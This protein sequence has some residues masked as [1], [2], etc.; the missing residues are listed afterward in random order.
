MILLLRQSDILCSENGLSVITIPQSKG[1]SHYEHL[2]DKKGQ[3]WKSKLRKTIDYCILKARNWDEFL[4][5][6]DKEKYEIKCGKYISFRAEGQER[7]TRS[8]TPE[9]RYFPAF[10]RLKC[11]CGGWI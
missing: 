9:Y 8:K 6:M 7:F 2:L 4:F 5:L 1:K 11:G 3:S 10:R